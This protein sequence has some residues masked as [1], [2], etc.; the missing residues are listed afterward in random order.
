MMP[1]LK[2]NE[3]NARIKIMINILDSC[4]DDGLSEISIEI[5]FSYR[6]RQR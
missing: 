1:H 4:T 3:G 6:T 5:Y 2:G